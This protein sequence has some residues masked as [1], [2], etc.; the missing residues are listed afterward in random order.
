MATGGTLDSRVLLKE[1]RM[2]NRAPASKTVDE[3]IGQFP[4]EVQETLRQLRAVIKK[5]APDA[6]ERI[7]Y[8]MPTYTMNRN[9]VHFAAYKNHIGFYP[10]P[11]GIDTFKAQLSLYEG[12]KGTVRF[13]IDAPLPFGLIERIVRFRVRE[14]KARAKSKT[15]GT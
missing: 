12:S 6:T 9:L 10:A 8:Q 2:K 11:S 13:P 15:K 1:R 3:Y 7:S 4:K 5:A 14:D